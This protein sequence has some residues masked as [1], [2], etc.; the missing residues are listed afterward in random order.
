MFSDKVHR[1]YRHDGIRS[2]WIFVSV[3]SYRD[4]RCSDTL[5]DLFAKARNPHRIMVGV[6]QQNAPG[7]PDVMTEEL[8]AVAKN[9]K[10]LRIPHHEARGP[11]WARWLCSHMWNG[12]TFFLQIDAHTKFQKN[13]DSDTKD[14]FN[15]L[16]THRAVITHYP[17][18]D[19]A[20]GDIRGKTVIIPT[21]EVNDKRE[22]IATGKE[23]PATTYPTKGKFVGACFLFARY[24]FLFEIPFDPYL[25][26][27]FQGEEPLLAMRLFT[28]GWG[29]YHPTHSVCT[30]YY[31]RAED[32]K[33][34]DDHQAQFDRWNPVARHRA[35][36]LMGLRKPEK[37]VMA[38]VYR[39]AN[40]YGAGSVRSLA[41][42]HAQLGVD[43]KGHF[44]D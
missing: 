43:W 42:W 23:V 32:P 6:C 36:F 10:V 9:I 20:S 3:A 41:E 1:K 18:S 4:S 25:P 15:L 2:D 24:N 29:I 27:L 14:M 12:E 17:P 22:L 7:D 39:N 21:A 11:T 5:V 31:V 33:F 40:V 16:G 37:G 30:H 8:K 13:W 26:Y 38:L 28:R 44:T 19:T 35:E 34:W